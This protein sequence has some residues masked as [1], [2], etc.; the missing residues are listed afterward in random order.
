MGLLLFIIM[1]PVCGQ[2]GGTGHVPGDGGI[3]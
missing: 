2:V 1:V 3:H